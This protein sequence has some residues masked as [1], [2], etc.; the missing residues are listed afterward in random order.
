[1]TTTDQPLL[2][3]LADT[4]SVLRREALAFGL[5]QEEI[6][7]L[8]DHGGW[9]RIRRGAYAAGDAWR[10]MNAESRHA[11]TAHAV[12]RLSLIHI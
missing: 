12:V 3:V 5:S 7:R 1:M 11:V 6:Q 9:V 4:G 2:P 10:S 8:V